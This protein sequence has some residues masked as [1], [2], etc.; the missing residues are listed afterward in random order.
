MA[1][2]LVYQTSSGVGP[3][4]ASYSHA[5]LLPGPKVLTIPI[6][7]PGSGPAL[8]LDRHTLELKVPLINTK[9]AHL[10]TV[11]RYIH[12]YTTVRAVYSVGQERVTVGTLC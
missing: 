4:G 6:P 12:Y 5:T 3:G 10:N 7:A 2:P 8:S 9:R 1:S 11:Y